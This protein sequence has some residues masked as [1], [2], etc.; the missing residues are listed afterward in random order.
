MERPKR[1][2]TVL[3]SFDPDLQFTMDIGG[4]CL[5]FLD[6]SITI[7]D[8][9]LVTLVYS[10]PTDAHLY[11]NAKSCHPKSQILGIARG[12]ALRIRRLCSD[13]GSDE[14]DFSNKSK[15]HMHII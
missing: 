1:F 14:V 2:F 12:E 8:N 4:K 6:L 9:C 3:N 15:E 11:L 13:K 10:K 5:N 7:S